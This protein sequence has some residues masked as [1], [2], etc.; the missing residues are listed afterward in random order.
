M[1]QESEALTNKGSSLCLSS[2][3][4]RG[5]PKLTQMH[6]KNLEEHKRDT[7]CVKRF[8]KQ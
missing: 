4:H 7:Y 6:R 8:E 5:R 3:Q 1:Q 2:V